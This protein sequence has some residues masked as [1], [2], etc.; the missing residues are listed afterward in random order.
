MNPA[1]AS[2]VAWGW[3]LWGEVAAAGGSL[4]FDAGRSVRHRLLT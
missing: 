2:S 3:L 4:H 1:I